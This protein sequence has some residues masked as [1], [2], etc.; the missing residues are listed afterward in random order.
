MAFFHGAKDDTYFGAGKSFPAAAPK[1]LHRILEVEPSLR[2]RQWDN[3]QDRQ[4]LL[5][6]LALPLFGIFP[7]VPKKSVILSLDKPMTWSVTA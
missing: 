6:L 2:N 7:V 3:A 1:R 4:S 5:N